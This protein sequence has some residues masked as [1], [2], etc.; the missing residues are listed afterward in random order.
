MSVALKTGLITKI[1]HFVKKHV[2][3]GIY[4]AVSCYFAAIIWNISWR[5]K[6]HST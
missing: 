2:I 1:A 3:D 4:D 6:T 5:L